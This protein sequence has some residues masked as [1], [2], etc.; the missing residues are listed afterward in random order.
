MADDVKRLNYFDKQFLHEQD[1]NDEQVYHIRHQRDH[2][3][4]LHTPGIAD[5]LNI[6]DPP[7]GATAVTIDAGVAFD[8]QGRRIVLANN[9]TLELDGEPADQ[10]IYVTIAYRETQ[11]DPTAETGI[12]G[13]TR[14]TEAPLIETSTTAPGN[15]N[16]RLVLAR[17][18]RTGTTVSSVDRSERRMAG[19]KGDVA[20]D[21]RVG[22]NLVVGG[23]IQGDIAV[24]I[25][26]PGDLADNAVTTAVIADEAVTGAKIADD[27]ITSAKIAEAVDTTIP[28]PGRNEQ[29]TNTGT[30]IKTGH[31]Q[32]HAVTAAKLADG[33]VTNAKLAD[34]AVDAAKIAD[35]SIDAAKLSDNAVTS[36]KIAEAVDGT[37]PIPDR[38]EQ[39]TNIG[40]GIKTGH[41]QNH[42]VTTAKL[43]DGAVTNAKLA[44]NSIDA[45]KIFE[46]SVGTNE[47]TEASVTM[48]KLGPEV[49]HFLIS[50]QATEATLVQ[51]VN[52]LI[53]R[54]SDLE[55]RLGGG[56]GDP[57]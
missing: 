8:D 40:T 31:L 22:G 41:L 4:L 38:N 16:A 49:V 20:G 23:T 43:A 6:P 18:V 30:G 46:G 57:T 35:G 32:N 54:V 34:N 39:N 19:V 48:P 24:G 25:V 33:A 13:N 5:G 28:S 1:F 2:A 29:N 36:A 9:R 45:S 52:N 7:A 26:Q 37:I 50:L 10:A 11:T 15:P 17:I 3:R 27:A 42:A 55:S 53:S 21:L 12:T 56:T 14:W 47:L 44:T 51:Q